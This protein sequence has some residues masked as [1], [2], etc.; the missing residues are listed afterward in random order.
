VRHSIAADIALADHYEV[1]IGELELA[2]LRQARI[3]DPNAL[4]LLSSVPGI[5]KVLALTILYEIH[6]ISRFPSVRDFASYCRLVKCERSSAGESL[7]TGGKKIGNAYLKWA[8]SEAAVLFIAKSEQAAPSSSA[9]SESTVSPR[10]CPSSP[11]SSVEPST[12]CSPE[13]RRSIRSASSQRNQVVPEERGEP[14]A[15]LEPLR[16]E[17]DQDASPSR[18]GMSRRGPIWHRGHQHPA[19]ISA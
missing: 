13:S 4:A 8:F 16:V 19:A 17:L 1:T 12:T 18:S 7:G 3:H 2:V 14:F 9:L 11:T 5:G 6:D 10:R 15:L